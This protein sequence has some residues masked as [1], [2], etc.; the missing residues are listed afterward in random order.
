MVPA[1][2]L[3]LST[4][5]SRNLVEKHPHIVMAEATNRLISKM[6]LGGGMVDLASHE[7]DILQTIKDIEKLNVPLKGWNWEMWQ[8]E[9]DARM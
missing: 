3:R 2:S 9:F 8:D 6:S 1:A 7:V 5:S 4:L